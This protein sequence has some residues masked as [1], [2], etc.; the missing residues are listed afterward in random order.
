MILPW[1]QAAARNGR[2][3]VIR[4]LV[5]L[6]ADVGDVDLLNRTALH[7]AA[8]AAAEAVGGGRGRIDGKRDEEIGG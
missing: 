8:R 4:R 5:R 1:G 6:G 3:D 2:G 7:Y